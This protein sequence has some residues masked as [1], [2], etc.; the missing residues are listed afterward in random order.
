MRRIRAFHLR[1]APPALSAVPGAGATFFAGIV[2]N[3][4]GFVHS[5]DISEDNVAHKKAV[6]SVF[7]EER[8]LS[9][10][11]KGRLTSFFTYL[12]D[13]KFGVDEMKLLDALAAPDAAPGMAGACP[14]G[15]GTSAPASGFAGYAEFSRDKRHRFR[16]SALLAAGDHL[17]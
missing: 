2:A 4:T 10:E 5:V 16:P 15:P 13:E 8:G 14:G 1:V 9:K 17:H 12:E 6:V 7:S 3:I 11:L